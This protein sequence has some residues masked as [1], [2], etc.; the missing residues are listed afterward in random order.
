MRQRGLACDRLTCDNREGF[1]LQIQHIDMT[2]KVFPSIALKTSHQRNGKGFRGVN[3]T[4]T[5]EDVVS[6]QT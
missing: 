5:H 6:R 4:R 1:P 2:E 3:V